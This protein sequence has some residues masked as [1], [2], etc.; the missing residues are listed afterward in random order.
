MMEN[1][2]Y[3]ATSLIVSDNEMGGLGC[4]LTGTITI[5]ITLILFVLLAVYVVRKIRK[6]FRSKR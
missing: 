2:L 6:H 4:M 3:P 1:L 5:V